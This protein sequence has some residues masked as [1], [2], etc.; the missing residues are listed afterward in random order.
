ML[1]LHVRIQLLRVF[2]HKRKHPLWLLAGQLQAPPNAC[3][4]GSREFNAQIAA[5]G[6][7]PQ[8]HGEI[9]N[10]FPPTPQV[11]QPGQAIPGI[12]EAP[13]VNDHPRVHVASSH[14]RHDVRKNSFRQTGDRALLGAAQAKKQRSRRITP[15]HGHIPA[16]QSSD[17]ADAIG[18]I[19]LQPGHH[20]RSHATPQRPSCSQQPIP[21]PKSGHGRHRDLAYRQRPGS[22][23]QI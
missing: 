22:R 15:G 20:Q 19:R 10:L 23:R 1:G 9:I 8:G 21:L 11:L 16:L 14:G 13:L 5:S 12:R 17:A 7:A 3:I 4:Q 18:W 6:N 2:A